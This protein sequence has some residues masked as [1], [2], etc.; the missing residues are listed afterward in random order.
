MSLLLHAALS[1]V[2]DLFSR[3]RAQGNWSARNALSS[4]SP[5]LLLSVASSLPPLVLSVAQLTAPL[6]KA[7]RVAHRRL[8]RLMRRNE[9]HASRSAGLCAEGSAMSVGATGSRWPAKRTMGSKEGALRRPGPGRLL[10]HPNL[11]Y[12]H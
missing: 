12:G 7:N 4:S 6:G 9:P 2:P 8:N 3:W 10:G 5:L 11:V 1:A